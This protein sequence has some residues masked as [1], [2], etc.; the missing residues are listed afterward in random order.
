MHRARI[1]SWKLTLGSRVGACVAALVTAASSA[2]AAP[3]APTHVACVG[4]SITQ[5][6]GASSGTTNYPADL[7]ALLGSAVHVMNYGHSGATLLSTGDLPYQRQSEY[8]SAT[9]FVSGAG[10]TATVDVI[11]MLGTND[12]KAY[13]WVVDAGTRAEQFRTDCSALVDHFAQLPTHPLVYLALPPTA[14]NNSYQI[15]GSVIHDQIIPILKQVAA[16]KGV[17]TIDVNTPTAGHAELFPDGVHPNDNGYKLLAQVMLDGLANGAAGADAA[18]GGSGG[19]G[20]GGAGGGAGATTMTGSGG[21]TS[22]M[23]D[24]G[25]ASVTDASDAPALGAGGASDARTNGLGGSGGTIASGAVGGS[26]GSAIGGGGSGGAAGASA[27]TGAGSSGGASASSAGGRGAGGAGGGAGGAAGGAASSGN[28][29]GVAMGLGGS[30]APGPLGA[31]R[32]SSGCSCAIGGQPRSH[33]AWSTFMCL[34]L[35]GAFFAN[36]ALARPRSRKCAPT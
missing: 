15:S 33:E 26:A 1:L 24:A 10:A 14:Y 29:G 32:S 2:A 16:A 12:S 8:T 36:R 9:S 19:S 21:A 28:A 7:Q 30:A 4:D 3:R 17:P 13:N 20:G 11:I 5:G 18:V 23:R 22:G 31:G 35:V 25:A 6:V 34:C 27:G